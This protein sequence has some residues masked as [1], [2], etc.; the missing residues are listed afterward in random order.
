MAIKSETERKG[1]MRISELG[2]VGGRRSRKDQINDKSAE[3]Q[4]MQ[5]KTES[6]PV[7]R[8]KA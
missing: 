1:K 4:T 7:L 6:K 2:S 3:K 5:T 8:A